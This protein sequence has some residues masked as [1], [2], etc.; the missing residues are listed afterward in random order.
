MEAGLAREVG[1]VAGVDPLLA[2]PLIQGRTTGVFV[3]EAV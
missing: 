1:V 2:L 3:E